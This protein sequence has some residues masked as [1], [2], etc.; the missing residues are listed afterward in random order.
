VTPPAGIDVDGVTAWFVASVPDVR[1]PLTFDLIAGGRSNLTYTVTDAGGRAFVLRR[2]PLGPLLPSAHDMAR[3][4][5]VQDAL[6]GTAV[7]VPPLAGLCT[8]EAVTGAPFYVMRHVDGLVLRDPEVVEAVKPAVRWAAAESLIDVLAALHDV[9][10]DAV[11]LGDLAR[12]EGYVERLLK[13]W[14]GQW[15]QSKTRELPLVE[16]VAE[17]LARDVPTQG[18]ASIVHGDYRLDNAIVSPDDGQV[19]AI[20]DWELCTLG[21]PLADVG[22]LL[23]YWT[24][25]GDEFSPLFWA[26]TTAPGF[27]GRKDIAA[28][29]AARSSRDLSEIDFYV[30]LALWKG[31]VILE[32]VHARFTSGAYGETDDSWRRFE[33]VVP[34]LA[35]AAAEA[36]TRAGR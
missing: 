6:A 10:P 8:D 25:P 11:G 31:A 12:K 1:P 35:E 32:G 9:D 19:Q 14:R 17:R 3:E 22:M 13:R 34:R 23:M 15:E 18:G 24:E 4:H 21:D 30:A 16:E 7:P 2:P 26:P 29:Y 28:R 5:R 27:P 33:E 36:A 20:L